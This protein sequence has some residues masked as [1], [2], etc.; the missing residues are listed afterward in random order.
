MAD[1][2]V[3]PQYGLTG[4]PCPEW[5]TRTRYLEVANRVVEA[6]R[7]DQLE[8][9]RLEF[10]NLTR[11]GHAAV[12]ATASFLLEDDGPRIQFLGWLGEFVDGPYAL[13]RLFNA[14]GCAEEIRRDWGNRE[15][16]DR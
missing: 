16:P 10:S 7:A 9:V 13:E 2:E 14:R 5:L 3:P 6:W 11:D 12:A 15:P 8:R 4:R 1:G